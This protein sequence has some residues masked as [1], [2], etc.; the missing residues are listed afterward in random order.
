MEDF[1]KSIQEISKSLKSIEEKRISFSQDFRK[2]LISNNLIENSNEMSLDKIKIAGIDG[3]ILKKSLHGIDIVIKR[4]VGVIYTFENNKLVKTDYFPSEFPSPIPEVIKDAIPEN[5]LGVL[6]N[7][8]RERKE[9]EISLQVLKKFKPDFLILD[10][11]IIPH[12]TFST[13]ST[14]II[15]DEWKKMIK[16]YIKMLSLALNMNVSV[17]GVIKDSRGK[18]FGEFLVENFSQLKNNPLLEKF[19]D[20]YVLSNV[21]QHKEFTI[22]FTY[23]SNPKSHPILKHF[24]EEI[25]SKIFCFYSKPS[26]Y[27][28]PLR[29]DFLKKGENHK[30]ITSL[31][32][33]L[34]VSDNYGIPSILIEADR[35][36]RLPKKYVEKL[37]TSILSSLG[38]S[39]LLLEK[40][41]ERRPI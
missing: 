18:R 2:F 40:R 27:D 38:F 31:L 12:Y 17:F 1:L 14:G 8:I 34:A 6:L 28:R 9:I 32:I 13:D 29:I 16:K 39:Y 22:P 21:L 11:S 19:K 25:S 15:S 5:E 10:G 23:S 24:P 37:Y 4:A 26:K 41:G 30:K 33:S 35:R 20:T 3:S 7:I 36:A